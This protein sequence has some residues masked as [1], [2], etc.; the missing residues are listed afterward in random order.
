VAEGYIMKIADFVWPEMFTA[1]IIT[2]RWA[3]AVC[4]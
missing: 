3:M 1:M 4:R 2:G